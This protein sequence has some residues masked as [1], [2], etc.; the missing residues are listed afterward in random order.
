MN[1]LPFF[2]VVVLATG[3]LVWNFS[4]YR[5]YYQAQAAGSVRGHGLPVEPGGPL[6]RGGPGAASAADG[7]SELA[8]TPRGRDAPDT[9]EERGE[10][11]DESARRASKP[12][13]NPGAGESRGPTGSSDPGVLE[14]GHYPGGTRRS[15]GRRV[16]GR[17][18]GTWVEW[19]EG[20]EP[21]SRG[22]Y[23]NDL[24]DGRWLYWYA[25]GQA[26]HEGDYDA[27]QREG[28][29]LSWHENGETRHEGRYRDGDR[30]G[31][32]RQWYSNSQVME[33]GRYVSGLR[34]GWWEFYDFEGRS[35][36]RAGWYEAGRRIR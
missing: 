10:L 5:G 23:E 4:F 28:Q 35:D 36:K 1:R 29:W 20:G 18:E 3:I 25:S 32:W 15:E 12:G 19:Y 33:A 34:E 21:L 9:S 11:G 7:T 27:G 8:D 13:G 31:M 24:R 22:R 17:R 2:T 30:E 6:L 16:D 14:T 26:Q